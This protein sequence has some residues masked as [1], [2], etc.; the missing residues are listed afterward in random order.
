MNQSSLSEPT[1]RDRVGALLDTA[2]L[3]D[4]SGAAFERLTRLVCRILD[5]PLAF[6]ALV[7]GDRQFFRSH[8]PLPES[9]RS[10]MQTPATKAFCRRVA[11]NREPL[12]VEDADM[13]PELAEAA[14]RA[15][16]ELAAYLGVPLTS[17]GDVLG[18]LAAIAREPRSWTGEEVRILDDLSALVMT[19]IE[20]RLAADEARRH[21]RARETL[22]ESTGEGIY[23]ID[24][25]GRCTFL[26]RAGSEMLGYAPEEVLGRNMHDLIH[27]SRED[28]SPYPVEEC[29]IFRAFRRGEGVRVT[30]E[31]LWRKDGTSFPADYSSFPI[32]EDDEVAGAVVTFTDVTRRR[33]REEERERLLQRE[34]AARAEAER[35]AREEAALRRAAQAIGKIFTVEEMVD[36][37]ARNATLAVE[38]D[39]AFVERIDLRADEVEF[40]TTTGGEVLPVG[41]RIPYTG[42]VAELAIERGEPEFL[43]SL[44]D[45]ETRLLR[46]LHEEWPGGSAIVVP[47]IDAGEAVGAL[48]LVRSGERGPFRNDEIER[49]RTFGDLAA[50]AFRK[51][52]LL[53]D[54][55]RKR[56]ELEQ[57]MESRA[58]LIR[59]FSH[60]VKNPL[61]AADGQ[62]QMLEMG[63]KGE[64]TSEQLDSVRRARATVK[65][66]LGL[67][68]DLVQLA[69]AE[70]GRL[71]I[72]W[73]PVDIREIA[74]ELAEDY[75]ARAEAKGIEMK[76]TLT[77]EMPLIESDTSRVRQVLGNLLSNAVKYT[78]E[79]RIHVRTGVVREDGGGEVTIEV[80]DTGPGIPDDHLTGLFREF[81][82]AEE[83]VKH[84]SGLGLAISERIARALGGR[85]TVES[86]VGAGS[87]FTIHLPLG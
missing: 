16:L 27:H 66:A 62:L 75:R 74:R 84:G 71:E 83:D 12:V 32:R 48:I 47:L 63:V 18:T 64:L 30:D 52:H 22:L 42:S 77:D 23:G 1:D 17:D 79:G 10:Q 20:L 31:V 29:S 68:D 13:H 7:E 34:R 78:D 60:D 36:E 3:D 51:V 45:T 2:L 5:V 54:S 55:E 56:E 61:G 9:F 80:S 14:I 57:V 26:N 4:R 72:E 25:R 76:L 41:S 6:V 33:R 40:V 58:R 86:E 59:G 43:P 65:G 53:H 44:D 69:R 15:D 73:E 81:S 67:I 19:E 50:F 37:I 85:I 38:A 11:R 8:A 35:R 28:G 49:A 87:T 82:R 39:A 70:A 46:K 21:A 24:R